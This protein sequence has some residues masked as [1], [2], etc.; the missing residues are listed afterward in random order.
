M[1][2]RLNSPLARQ[3]KH[4]TKLL[5]AIGKESVAATDISEKRIHSNFYVAIPSYVLNQDDETM[6][7][8]SKPAKVEKSIPQRIFDPIMERSSFLDRSQC[9]IDSKVT[10][11]DQMHINAL[12]ISLLGMVSGQI[13]VDPEFAEAMIRRS[14]ALLFGEASIAYFIADSNLRF[15]HSKLYEKGQNYVDAGKLVNYVL[16]P[17]SFYSIL[18]NRGIPTVDIH[19]FVHHAA[20][21]R[22]WPDFFVPFY[23]MQY[24]V[25]KALKESDVNEKTELFMLKKLLTFVSFATAEYSVVGEKADKNYSFG[26]LLYQYPRKSPMKKLDL[27]KGDVTPREFTNWNSLRALMSLRRRDLEASYHFAD[28]KDDWLEQLGYKLPVEYSPTLGNSGEVISEPVSKLKRDHKINFKKLS[29]PSNPRELLS[30]A[31]QLIAHTVD[32]RTLKINQKTRQELEGWLHI[33]SES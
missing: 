14:T 7:Q 32:S 3:Y 31:T 25:Q 15:A 19:D 2:E 26:C 20:Q 24:I 8:L 28:K 9:I 33:M 23:N 18:A 11:S 12:Y 27:L 16:T 22:T 6:V 29:F 10:H 13:T 17:E 1:S 4:E 5:S 30:N 21:F